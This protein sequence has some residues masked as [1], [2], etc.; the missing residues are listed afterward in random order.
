MLNLK[1]LDHILII[2]GGEEHLFPGKGKGGQDLQLLKG[3]PEPLENIAEGF[4]DRLIEDGV[5]I[6]VNENG[7]TEKG[8]RHPDVVA[9]Q[10][11]KEVATLSP[12]VDAP[13][14]DA[15]APTA[16]VEAVPQEG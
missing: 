11:D 4:A 10:G 15:P 7:T 8:R 13:F 5:A 14:A 6:R 3:V 2:R 9:K 16:D 1:H 12:V